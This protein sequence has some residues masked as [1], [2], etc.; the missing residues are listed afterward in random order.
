MTSLEPIIA[1]LVGAGITAGATMLS[2]FLSAK[3]LL[4]YGPILSRIYDVVDP[5]LERNMR[6]WSGSDVEFAI[7][8]AIEAIADTELTAKELRDMVSEI[9]KRWL[10]QVAADKVRR[11]EQA[12]EQPKA[13][14]AADVLANVVSGKVTKQEALSLAKK[15]LS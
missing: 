1:L 7:E 2:R 14:A 11:F 9:S 10:P 15:L 4:K 3:K 13:L 5:L 12:A 6:Q 8:L